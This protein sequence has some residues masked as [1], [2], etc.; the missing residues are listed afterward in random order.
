VAFAGYGK[1]NHSR[2]WYTP[3]LEARWDALG[4]ERWAGAGRQSL[5]REGRLGSQI[6]TSVHWKTRLARPDAFWD[7]ANKKLYVLGK[8]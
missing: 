3:A 5:H 8:P 1:P 7:D 4:Q 6:F 2:V